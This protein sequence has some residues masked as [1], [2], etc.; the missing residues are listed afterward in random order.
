MR[1]GEEE[2]GR[3]GGE[4]GRG[5]GVKEMENGKRIGRLAE[6]NQDN[7]EGGEE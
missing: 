2:E 3:R 5:E 1:K 4:G 7:Y 6:E